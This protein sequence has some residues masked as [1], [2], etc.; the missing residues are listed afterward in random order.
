MSNIRNITFLVLF[1]LCN[2]SNADTN[3]VYTVTTDND[4]TNT[5]NQ[6]YKALERN[7]LYVVFEPDIGANIAGFAERW[8]QNYNRNKLD[9]IKSMIFCNGWYANEMSNMDVSMTA[10]C[11]LHLTLTKHK[12]LTSIHF[13]RP[14]FIAKGSKAE[15]VASEL[16]QLVIK[17]ITEGIEA[18]KQ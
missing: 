1:T 13:V 6:L 16:T 3:S 4:F 2:I 18:A 17:A 9:N 12:K 5:Y 14:D 15:N 11:P 8:G 7:N 10:I